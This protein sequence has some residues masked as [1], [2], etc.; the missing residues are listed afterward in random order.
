MLDRPGNF[1]LGLFA[2]GGDADLEAADRLLS[3]YLSANANST[4]RWRYLFWRGRIAERLN[5]RGTAAA[6]FRHIV[7]KVPYDYYGLRARM[8]LERGEAASHDSIPSPESQIHRELRAAYAE[9]HGGVPTDVVAPTPYHRRVRQAIETGL[10][11]QLLDIDQELRERIDDVSLLDLDSNGMVPFAALLVS[12]RQDV[13]AAKDY[14][15]D[16]DNWLQVMALVSSPRFQDWPVT[17]EMM[18]LRND[19]EREQ[20]LR[21]QREV[22]YLATVYPDMERIPAL[23]EPLAATS[24]DID[25][26]PGL[27]QAIMYAVIRHESGFYPR[28]IST[29]GALGLFQFMPQTFRALTAEQGIAPN[30]EKLSELDYLLDPRRNMELWARWVNAEFPIK[31]SRDIVSSMMRHQAGSG[32]VA[33]WS[34]YWENAG[35]H[36]DLEFQIET[37]RF[38]ATRSFLRRVLRDTMIVDAAGIFGQQGETR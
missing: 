18:F 11:G 36:D 22:P 9:S 35:V 33:E 28:A 29:Q 21:L 31:R 16:A 5:N 19:V 32:N 15:L 12:M 25:D 13:L 7:D 3:E 8:H 27:S 2:R 26:A 6:F 20:W 10:Y 17:I 24:W 38:A 23:T 34:E 14:S 30:V 4:F 1:R 37:V